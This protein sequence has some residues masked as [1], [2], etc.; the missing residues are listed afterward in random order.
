MFSLFRRWWWAQPLLSCVE[1]G[2]AYHTPPRFLTIR[3]HDWQKNLGRLREGSSRVI[4]QFRSGE[5]MYF[6]IEATIKCQAT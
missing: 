1:G 4:E 2:G 5:L 6:Y 3:T